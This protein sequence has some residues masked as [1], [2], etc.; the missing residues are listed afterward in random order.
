MPLKFNPTGVVAWKWRPLTEFRASASPVKRH[1]ALEG[2]A[3]M[4]APLSDPERN[5]TVP[6]SDP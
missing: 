2:S 5:S 3:T 1:Y 6:E 4:A